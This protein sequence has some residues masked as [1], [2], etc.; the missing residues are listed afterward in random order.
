MP[1]EATGVNVA[2]GNLRRLRKIKGIGMGAFAK[3]VEI[4]YGYLSQIERGHRPS[5]SP[6]AFDRICNR[7]D[8]TEIESRR[9]LLADSQVAA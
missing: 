2:G 8:L 6:E 9:Q 3:S 5:I 7:L 4:S 1:N